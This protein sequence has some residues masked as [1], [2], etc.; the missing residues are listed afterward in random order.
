MWE[1]LVATAWSR[2][3][4]STVD[5]TLGVEAV[6]ASKTHKHVFIYCGFLGLGYH[7]KLDWRNTSEGLSGVYT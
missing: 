1:L 7:V 2:A 6:F 5:C 3:V 4:P